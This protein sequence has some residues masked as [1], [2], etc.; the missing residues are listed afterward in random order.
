[1]LSLELKN[2]LQKQDGFIS[3]KELFELGINF[4]QIKKLVK[5]GLL[6]NIKRGL[7][8]HKKTHADNE[9]IHVSKIVPNGVFC[10]FSAWSI[11]ELTDIITAN[12][13][14]AIEKTQKVK[15]PTYPPIKLYYWSA[16][17]FELGITKTK[18]EGVE[19]PIYNLEKSVCDAVRFR[20]KI[21]IDTTNEVLK[22]YLK[23]PSKNLDELIYYGKKLR[24]EKT[25]KTYLSILL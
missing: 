18:I 13:H 11:Y 24:I 22:N 1:M 15:L 10:L 3:T 8:F 21:G 16:P 9:F 25:L 23:R 17:Y 2:I 6:E 14:V 19:V 20:N 7:Y 4:Y 5:N 12:Y